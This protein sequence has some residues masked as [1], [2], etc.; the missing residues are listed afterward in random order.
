MADVAAA[1]RALESGLAAASAGRPVDASEQF[2]AVLDALGPD[3]GSDRRGSAV[4]PAPDGAL[5]LAYIRARALLGLAMSEL[6][7][8]G[9]VAGAETRLAEAARWAARAGAGALEVAVLGQLGLVR[10]RSGDPRGALAALDEATRHL[11]AAEPVDACRILLNRGSLLLELGRLDAARADLHASAERARAAGDSLR[12]FKARHNLGYA[13]FL[14]GDLPAALAAMSE[15]ASVEHGASPAV[16]LLDRAQVLVDA[17]LVAEADQKLA[18]A[19]RTFEAEQLEHDLAHT[20]LLRA[21]CALLGR[22]PARALAWAR[23]A[24]ERFAARGNDPWLARAELVEAQARLAELLDGPT[25]RAALAQVAAI[26]TA[27]AQR[28]H[29]PGAQRLV[30]DAWLTAAEAHAAAGQV[31]EARAALGRAGRGRTRAPLPLAVR[32]CLVRARLAQLAG[33]ARAARRE[34]RA[35]QRLLAEHRSQ[36]GSVEAVAAAAV[37]GV[38]L[39]ELDIGAALAAGSPAGVLEAVER[40]RATF[41]GPAR[42]RPPE[43]PELRAL[44]SELR[45]VVERH[46]TLGPDGDVA[47]LR[48]R[49][50]LARRALELRRL[51]RERSWQLGGGLAPERAARASEVRRAVRESATTVLDV[52]VHDGE[53]LGVVVDGSGERLERL[54]PLAEVTGTLRRVRADLEVLARPLDP[55]LASVV[56]AS[57]RRGLRTLDTLLLAPVT[58]VGALHVVARGELATVPWGALPSRRGLATSVASRLVVDAPSGVGPRGEVV[59]LAGPGLRHAEE[60]VRM[61]A[62][63]WPSGQVRTG[64]EA[65]CGAAAQ[66]LREAAVV[67][68]AAHGHHEVD[69][70]V[71][72][73]V[74]LADGPLFAH[75]L[76]GERLP[77]SVVVLSACEV[78]RVTERPGGEALGLASVLLRL[79]ARAVVA[80]LAPLRDELAAEVM[81]L[82][83]DALADGAAPAD[84]LAAAGAQV[85]IPVPLSCF[86]AATP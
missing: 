25:D 55:R 23:A 69:N 70:P 3:G 47:A 73:W 51:A 36:F 29:G 19:A 44:L 80:A 21:H 57:L 45:Q 12:G 15:A 31:D 13:H 50:E 56:E 71:F 52:L 74:R 54:A 1:R 78:G 10:M 2:C 32:R 5:D 48:E 59:A 33:D 8:S 18:E 49:D 14:A 63:R 11:E 26:A 58:G 6:E 4:G 85:E 39:A 17:G 72:S 62:A 42:V 37:H 41:A 7:L 43:D 65:S 77:G 30:R 46:R 67:H 66:A 76:E 84:A 20:E 24:R 38:R 83:H 35:G 22:E 61:V 68:L 28:E 40:G 81:P 16:A 64:E 34:V 60:E 9:D 27:L 75:E 53:V 79:G 82:V 86:V